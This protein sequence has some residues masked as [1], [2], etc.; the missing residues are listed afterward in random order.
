MTTD[1]TEIPGI[2][3][4]YYEQLNTN[5]M[6]SLQEMGKF[7]ERY[8][9]PRLNQEEI[10]NMNRQI[11]STEIESMIKNFSTN[12]SSEPDSFTGEFSQI[13]REELAFIL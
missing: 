5:K 9:L 8:S 4:D 2:I 10:E 13:F 1:S 12:K 3:I 6:G 11:T 7:L